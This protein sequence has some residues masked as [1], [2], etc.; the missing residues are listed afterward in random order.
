MA[1]PIRTAALAALAA[2]ILASSAPEASANSFTRWVEGFWPSA[3]AAGISR[4]T[5]DAAF[6]G[7]TSPDPEVLKADANQAEFKQDIWDYL[8][9][10]VSERRIETGLLMRKELEPVLLQVEQRYKVDR[11][12][13]L[14]IFG[15]ETSYG[16]FKGDK[17][18]IRSLATLAHT[19]RRQKFGR[20]Q[21][22][23]ALKILQ[24]GDTT[25]QRMN[26]SWAGAMG[27]TQFIPTTYHLYA[28][29][30]NGDGRRDIWDTLPDA[31][32][33]TAQLLRKNGWRYGETWGYE[34]VVPKG[35]NRG[36]VGG[37]TQKTI[38]EWQR[39][40]VSR[41]GGKGF[42]RPGDR[43]GLIQPGGADGPGFLVL[44]NFRMIMR[45]NAA[46]AYALGVGHLADRL[47]G[48]GPIQQEWPR[49][50][51]PMAEKERME[52]QRRLVEKG[53]LQGEIDGIMGS[54]TVEALKSFQKAIGVTADGYPTM[55]MLERLRQES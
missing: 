11:D 29:D 36:V 16:K 52:M 5:Y 24:N 20:Q 38:A 54:A 13:V 48:F 3:R 17:S 4:A 31:L 26:G 42:P 40:G 23:A 53:Y 2:A 21:L 9:R 18:V 41:P 27:F 33:S 47:K 15:M 51:P 43:A 12:I 7:V 34:V 28:Q 45:Y 37:K 46:H 35:F 39:L 50:Y 10:A 30:F 1:G 55:D 22:I 49:K 14:A 8:D 32:A 25:P 19:G 6:Q 44:H